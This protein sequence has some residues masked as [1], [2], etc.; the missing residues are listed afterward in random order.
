MPRKGL[1][2]RK[3][4]RRFDLI[5]A[6]AITGFVLL[7]YLLGPGLLEIAE[8]QTYD[9]RM[10]L[11]GPP[12]PATRVAI[13]AIDDVSM[14]KLGRWPWPRSHHAALI[15]K[16]KA[17][18]A[19]VIAPAIQFQDPEETTG[20]Q[21]LDRLNNYVDDLLLDKTKA[22][23]EPLKQ[24]MVRLRREMDHD[25]QLEQAIQEAGNVV[26]LM[27]MKST[28][29][30]RGQPQ[31]MP[32]PAYVAQ[33]AF[34]LVKNLGQGSPP[35]AVSCIPPLERF[36]R[37][38]VGMGPILLPLD[39]DG[40]TRSE[41]LVVAYQDDLYPAFSLLVA[42]RVLGVSPEE[43]ICHLGQ[44]ITLGSRFVPTDAHMR[45]FV[46]Y[47]GDEKTVPHFSFVD[48]LEGRAS[49]GAFQGKAV[50]VGFTAVGLTDRL[51][52]PLS[53]QLSAVEGVAN[54]VENILQSSY[55]V[56]PS[57][58]SLLEI[59]ILLALGIYASLLLPRLRALMGALVTLGLFLATGVLLFVLFQGGIWIRMVPPL[60]LLLLA[61]LAVVSRR[62]FV[63]EQEK[64]FVEE[65]SDAANKM[66]GLAFQGK[67]MLDL[68]F[69]KFRG[70]P[71]DEEMK[72][73]LYNL[74][75]DFERK[76]QPNKAISVYDHIA[77]ADP[78][79]KDIP[80]R[81]QK[82]RAAMASTGAPAIPSLRPKEEST[83]M[84]EG[85]SENPTLGR[86]E[87]VGELGKGAMGIVYKGVDPKIHR[88]VAIKTIR[89]EQDFDPEEIEDDKKRFF[90]EAE[91]AGRLTHPNIV[92]VYD[93][94]EDWDLSYIA[95]ELLEGADLVAHTKKGKLLPIRRVMEII[96]QS[97]DALDYA[98]EQGVVHRD[99]K[100]AN[101]MLLKNG[102]V[103]VT[104]FGI[105]RITTGSRTQTAAGIVMG[106]PSYMSPEQVSG[107]HV[108]G[109][110]DIFSLGV[111]FYELLTGERPFKAEAIMTLLHVIA[112]QPH[113]PVRTYNPRVPEF[114]GK[115]IDKALA[116]DPAARFQR[117]SEM[118]RALRTFLAK[119]DQ[120]AAA[121]AKAP[122]GPGSP[123]AR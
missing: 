32:P 100:P 40:A 62:F 54:V 113:T 76:R 78:N 101:I 55:M 7:L 61:Y 35:R 42:A 104:D 8:L 30:D 107:H 70:L 27:P 39:P 26:L 86:Y 58:A 84:L 67:G 2:A 117:G 4:I 75:L 82:I 38:T 116:K 16:L 111:V 88:E 21:V 6:G 69:E 34:R 64:E 59:G 73:I 1:F 49:R 87:I 63:T 28:S 122:A 105:A 94:G 66:L 115:V 72:D 11:C 33:Q 24:E 19:N 98:H 15:R 43:V 97:C 119:V 114:L 90:R 85:A 93:V 18:G 110:S 71:V 83:V 81:Q 109:R 102:Q 80:S 118:A 48:V 92:T 25:A 14:G 22:P 68:A 106:T 56:R 13:V 17:A 3:P 31:A 91:T 120:A 65:E 41:N 23:L 51:I 121:K 57:W 12:G 89:F 20:L 50:L 9:L 45:M 77:S 37:Q 103:K 46:R 123:G 47:L 29:P 60:L 5:S 96:A 99:V 95:M 112:T 74:A 36:S 108:D 53:P 10:R 44:G 79:Y 52:T